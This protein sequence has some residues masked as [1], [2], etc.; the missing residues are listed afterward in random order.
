MSKKRKMSPEDKLMCAI[1]CKPLSEVTDA[2]IDRLRKKFP[3]LMAKID[4]EQEARLE[5][6]IEEAVNSVTDEDFKKMC[7]F[8][9]EESVNRSMLFAGWLQA[10]WH[11]KEQHENDRK[12]HVIGDKPKQ[13]E[14]T[15]MQAVDMAQLFYRQG[16]EDA[17]NGVN[18]Y[19]RLWKLNR[20]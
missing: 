14:F 5:A 13:N 1:Y 4:A 7:G 12:Y 20:K 9:I 2:D 18:E 3:K 19:D 11:W 16:Q 15:V 6:E 17:R 10:V 8:T